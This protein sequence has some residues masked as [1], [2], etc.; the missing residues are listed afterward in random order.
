MSNSEPRL[1]AQDAPLCVLGVL[2]VALQREPVPAPD[3]H[4]EG[5]PLRGPPDGRAV[6]VQ[7][8]RQRLRREAHRCP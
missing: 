5:R 7:R 2:P 3:R 1:G 4:P 8:R 6:H